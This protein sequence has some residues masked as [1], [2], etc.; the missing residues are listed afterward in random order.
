[1]YITYRLHIPNK[2]FILL[3]GNNLLKYLGLYSYI[4]ESILV[5]ICDWQG[6][7]WQGM[8]SREEKRKGNLCYERD[9]ESQSHGQEKC[10]ISHE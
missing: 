3:W 9:V 1:M 10:I 2:H 7:L 6:W 8:A 4:K 5:L